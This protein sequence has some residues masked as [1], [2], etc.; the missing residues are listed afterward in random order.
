MK[1]GKYDYTVRFPKDQSCHHEVWMHLALANPRGGTHRATNMTNAYTSK[2]NPLRTN[3]TKKD[4][5]HTENKPTIRTRRSH[6]YDLYA[7]VSTFRKAC[8]T[9]GTSR[10]S[11]NDL[12]RPRHPFVFLLLSCVSLAC[13]SH[14]MSHCTCS[15]VSYFKRSA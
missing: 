6:P 12:M 5:G 4:D 9:R 14:C 2:K 15:Y 11:F 3:T 8:T 7:P 1:S 13:M 10:P